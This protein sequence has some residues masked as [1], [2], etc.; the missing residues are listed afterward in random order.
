MMS[1]A[2]TIQNLFLQDKPKKKWICQVKIGESICGTELADCGN[3]SGRT[4]HIE[5]KHPHITLIK[6]NSSNL[7][8]TTKETE[9]SIL[10]KLSNTTHAIGSLKYKKLNAAVLEYLI[11]KNLPLSHAD[12]PV[13]LNL[14]HTFD[15]KHNQRWKNLIML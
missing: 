2:N 1:I 4:K 5:R 9:D 10:D 8:K 13:F 15:A 6:K 7:P 14:L 11:L 3:V 12:D